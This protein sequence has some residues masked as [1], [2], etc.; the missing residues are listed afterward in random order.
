MEKSQKRMKKWADEKRRPSVYTVGDL[1]L[2]KLLPQQF[3]PFRSQPK[4]LIRRYEGSFEVVGKVGKVSYQLNLPDTLKIHPVF[5]VSML[6]PYHADM[7]DQDRGVSTR[8]QPV[9]TKSYEKEIGEVL[10][11]KEVRKRGIPRQAHFLIKW[12]GLLETEATWEPEEDL[13]QFQ[14]H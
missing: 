6:K 8:A 2:G 11:S 5:H 1:V 13:W 10:A 14:T 3:K 7:D 12:K 9:M 4:G